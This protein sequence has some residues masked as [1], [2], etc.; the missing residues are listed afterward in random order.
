MIGQVVSEDDVLSHADGRR[1]TEPSDRGGNLRYCR[2]FVLSLFFFFLAEAA[3]CHPHM[4]VY[5]RIELS[6]NEEKPGGLW[7]EYR[8]DRYFSAD[9]I[10]GFDLDKNGVFDAAET[11]D[12]HDHAFI[13]MENY[14]FFLYL[15]Q[16]DNR[17]SPRAV[18]HFSPRIEDGFIIYRFY[19]DLASLLTGGEAK[20]FF[21]SVF[22]TT[23]FCACSYEEETPVLF[24][25]AYHEGADYSIVRNKYYPVYYDPFAPVGDTT[26]HERWRPGLETAYPEEVRIVY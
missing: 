7:M 15:R 17:V 2:Y 21:L 25:G 20:E 4:A 14:G 11:Q 1:Q 22:D 10:Y 12:I 6:F 8:F 9:I 16:G 24:S 13:N 5:S 18:S 26:I 19:V 3:F 23:Y